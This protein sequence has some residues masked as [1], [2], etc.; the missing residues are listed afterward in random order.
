M[1]DAKLTA[2]AE[3]TV[4]A[5]GDWLYMVDVSDTSGGT[6][7]TSKKVQ[8]KYWAATD[9]NRALVTG[10]GTVA[11]G[12]YTL[13][14]PATGTMVTTAAVQTLTGKT[15]TSPIVGGTPSFSG[16]VTGSPTFSGAVVFSGTATTTD[17]LGVGTVTPAARLHVNESADA[18]TGVR[19]QNINTGTAAGAV[20]SL[21]SNSGTAEAGVLAKY[22]SNHATYAD[23]VVLQNREGMVS[24][25]TDGGT[26]SLTDPGVLSYSGTAFGIGGVT[27]RGAIHAHDGT[28]GFLLSTVTVTGTPAT[29]I[30]NGTG[31]VT[32][33]VFYQAI[34]VDNTGKQTS[35]SGTMIP[36]GTTNT[37]AT[38][39]GNTVVLS[40]ESDGSVLVTRALGTRTF[41]VTL[42]LMWQ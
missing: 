35:D 41:T 27:P 12:G 20:I 16:T 6:A 1:A 9:G 5:T 25:I 13:T 26:V 19:L 31:D 22:G 10:G 23:R 37:F 3:G 36:G 4:V 7:G 40:C 17:N 18:L 42:F 15:L 39:S 8:A 14:V 2:K 30:A 33:V 34:V 29:V 32:Q 24:L 38:E 21:V 11:L 28:G